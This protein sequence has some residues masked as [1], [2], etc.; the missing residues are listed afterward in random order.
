MPSRV[1]VR[2][3]LETRVH[4][5][6]V[7]ATWH[8]LL[9]FDVTRRRYIEQ[10]VRVYGFEAPLETMLAYV[11]GLGYRERVRSGLLVEDL[12]V[13]GCLPEQIARFSLCAITACHDLVDALGWQYALE[14]S[15]VLHGQ[16]QRHLV[17]RIPAL[18]RACSYL[19]VGED[20]G[21]Q[22][23]RDYSAQVD[24]TITTLDRETRLLE[25]AHA[26]LQCQRAWYRGDPNET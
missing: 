3:S 8:A 17:A 14:R 9:T 4:H 23:W 25:A 22:R 13:L 11:P 7:D 12:L 26:A 18:A 5:A 21:M 15:N 24:E 16:L 2:L 20:G 19:A 6:A 1:L 10:L